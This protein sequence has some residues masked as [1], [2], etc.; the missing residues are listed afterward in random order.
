MVRIERNIEISKTIS[1]DILRA[2]DNNVKG[3]K[4]RKGIIGGYLDELNEGDRNY[5][6]SYL[7][8]HL[9]DLYSVYKD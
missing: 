5:I 1:S 9:N 6:N 7:K 3:F 2:K 8:S 4:T